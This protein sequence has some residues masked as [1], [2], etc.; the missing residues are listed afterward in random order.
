MRLVRRGRPTRMKGRFSEKLLLPSFSSTFLRKVQPLRRRDRA[1]PCRIWRP[2]FAPF[3]PQ[4]PLTSRRGLPKLLACKGLGLL[5]VQELCM[6]APPSGTEGWKALFGQSL[7]AR[8]VSAQSV[9]AERPFRTQCGQTPCAR[10]ARARG[11]PR[12]A[13]P[14]CVFDTRPALADGV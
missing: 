8:K 5:Y 11:V 6:G 14:L 3:A 1:R 13:L 12:G 2:F 7:C 10:R 9:S 4:N